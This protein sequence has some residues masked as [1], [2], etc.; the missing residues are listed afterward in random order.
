MV[1]AILDGQKTQTRRIVKPQPPGGYHIDTCHYNDTGWAFWVSADDHMGTCTCKNLKQPYGSPGD[2]L[3]VRETFADTGWPPTGPEYAYR[4]DT[5]HADNDTPRWKPSIHMPR[6]ASRITLEVVSVRVER[7]QECS[8]ADAKAEGCSPLGD[9]T[10][11]AYRLGYMHLWGQIN[12]PGSWDA[13]PWVWVVSFNRIILVPIASF[14]RPDSAGGAR[15]ALLE[16]KTIEVP[17]AEVMTLLRFWVASGQRQS[18]LSVDVDQANRGWT[19]L[20]RL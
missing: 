3:W 13:N 7:L 4:A 15:D 12:G 20:R 9:D 8:E 16:G 6:R 17:N 10:S 11:R 19:V 18:R 1:R 2:R 5:D 14:L